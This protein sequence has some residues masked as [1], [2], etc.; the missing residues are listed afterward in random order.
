MSRCGYID[1]NCVQS[2]ASVAPAIRQGIRNLRFCSQ[3]D[4]LQRL[5]CRQLQKFGR[6]LG[7]GLGPRAFNFANLWHR[8]DRLLISEDRHPNCQF[9]P[10]QHFNNSSQF[11]AFP[12][13]ISDRALEISYL[14]P[15]QRG[16]VHG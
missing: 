7:L 4:V 10:K 5:S 9:T 2:E 3:L 16:G 12:Y 14:L 15:S 11:P 1:C 8:I 13:K 6:D